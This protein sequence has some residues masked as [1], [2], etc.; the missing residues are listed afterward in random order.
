VL[1]SKGAREIDEG[2][3]VDAVAAADFSLRSLR[4]HGEVVEDERSSS[5]DKAPSSN[6]EL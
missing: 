2:A 1:E 6:D 5:E 3:P 4:A